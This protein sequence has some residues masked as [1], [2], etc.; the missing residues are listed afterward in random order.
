LKAVNN[1]SSDALVFE[2]IHKKIDNFVT[3][4]NAALTFEG[5]K[6]LSRSERLL[7]KEKKKQKTDNSMTVSS[8]FRRKE[9][10]ISSNDDS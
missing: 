9:I 7:C 3:C 6:Y 8:D 10:I 4:G 2:M 5:V 1:R